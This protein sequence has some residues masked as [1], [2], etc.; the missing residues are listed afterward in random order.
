MKPLTIAEII[1]ATQGIL[2]IGDPQ[3]VVG[4]EPQA[5][6]DKTDHA[7]Q[8]QNTLPN[9][10]PYGVSIDSRTLR[11]G[12]IFFAIIGDRFDGHRFINESVQKGASVCIVSHV[13]STL[14]I[15]LSNVTTIIKVKDTKKALAD[16]AKYY[17][18][19]YGANSQTISI[20]G[21]CGKT[22]VKEM[23]AQILSCA[24][25]TIYSPGNYN[26]DI[27]CPLSLF[28]INPKYTYSVFEIGGS[29]KG[30]VKKLA[31]IVSPQVAVITNIK[32]EHTATF[33]TLEDIAEGESEVLPFL[34]DHGWAV[35][36]FDDLFFTFLKSKTPKNTLL[37][38]FG[39]SKNAS[40]YISQF[41][42][43]PGPTQFTIIHQD[44]K[45]TILDQFE[46]TLPVMGKFNI[47]NACAAAATCFCLKIP[48]ET[49]QKGLTR[50]SPP[51]MRFQLIH[52]DNNVVLVNDSYN[53]N[54]G[55][56]RSALESFVECFA[57]KQRC[58]ILGDMLELGE[59]SNKEHYSLGNF[60]A[61]LPLSKVI[62]YGP[63]SK[64]IAEGARNSMLDDRVMTHCTDKDALLLKIK[65]LLLPGTAIL[66]KASRGMHL[67][68]LIKELSKAHSLPG[69]DN[70]SIGH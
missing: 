4:Q 67:D 39:F 59:I 11:R 34:P 1:A 37:K 6:S 29:A 43:W 52:L 8:Y 45:G 48:A 32:L 44:S 47:L 27:G 9:W 50:F 51:Q 16:C 54:P 69:L 30:D 13:P 18:I 49:I 65:S 25:P 56:M 28:S 55:S 3:T 20:S 19:K 63:H 40:V 38:S 5:E 41:S 7:I 68:E 23:I 66:F 57:D 46:C 21:S 10:P 24:A 61:G 70:A 53:A 12:D 35:L 33:G 42:T 64:F 60:L 15:N 22:T 36:P 2:V 26:N 17:K 14:N 62:L 31:E 58:V